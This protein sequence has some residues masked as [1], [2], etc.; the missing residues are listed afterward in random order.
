MTISMPSNSRFGCRNP[1]QKR[2]TLFT[3]YTWNLSTKLFLQVI[4]NI[5]QYTAS[6]RVREMIPEFQNYGSRRIFVCL[7]FKSRQWER[8]RKSTNGL[9]CKAIMILSRSVLKQNCKA[10]I[11]TCQWRVSCAQI[12]YVKN[13]SFIQQHLCAWTKFSL[14]FS[15]ER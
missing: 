2:V 1:Y 12:T 9:I 10:F 5:S 7:I 8:S 4:T 6:R 11:S 13:D 14:S 3:S 15:S